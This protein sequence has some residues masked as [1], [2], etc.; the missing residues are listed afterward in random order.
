MTSC[1]R[2]SAPVHTFK[3]DQNPVL[4][5]EQPEARFSSVN[6]QQSVTLSL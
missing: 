6:L 2:C 1:M 4:N 5:G 3:L